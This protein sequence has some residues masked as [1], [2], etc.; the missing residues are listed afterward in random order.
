MTFVLSARCQD[1]FSETDGFQYCR[2]SDRIGADDDANPGFKIN[3]DLI[4][5]SKVF[6]A[7]SFK[8]HDPTNPKSSPMVADCISGVEGWLGVS[9]KGQSGR[10]M[11]LVSGKEVN[12]YIAVRSDRGMLGGG[13]RSRIGASIDEG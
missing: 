12:V 3:G 2:L 7:K 9:R 13:G 5:G 6:D 10:S 11:L 8:T 1:G 4:K